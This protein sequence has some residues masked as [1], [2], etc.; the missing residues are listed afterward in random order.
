MSHTTFAAIEILA[1][2]LLTACAPPPPPAASCPAAACS[3][4]GQGADDACPDEGQG[5]D[6]ACPHEGHGTGQG[7]SGEGACPGARRGESRGGRRG[8]APGG[9]L[10]ATRT[11][12]GG[13]ALVDM[14]SGAIVA[15][16]AGGG[17]DGPEADIACDPWMSRVLVF[18]SDPDAEWGEIAGHSIDV[19]PGG[20]GQPPSV[21]LGARE[22]EVWVDGLARVAASPYGALVFEDG[23]AG[24][25]WKLVSEQGP[26]PSAYGPR[27]AS[28]AAGSGPGGLFHAAALTYGPSSDGLDLRFATVEQDG[29]HIDSVEPLGLSPPGDWPSARAA[30]TAAGAHLI[31][32]EQGNVLV[33]LVSGG[34]AA[35]WASVPLAAPIDGFH[36]AAALPGGDVLVGLA[37]GGADVVAVRLGPDGAP[38]CAAALDLPGE[39]Q[40]GLLFFS[41]G[42]TVAGPG[43]VLAATSSG[44]FAVQVTGMCP[45]AVALDPAF[46][47]DALRGPLD[48]C[49]AGH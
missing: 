17:L 38:A 21:A 37:S 35:P 33:S 6:D 9:A 22:H 1:A 15:E 19:G 49:P 14:G 16:A 25:R 28:L 11:A 43:R 45:L 44:V 20:G 48:A 12:T 47:G 7:G 8:A 26:T 4:S 24:P 18:E 23:A 41:R 39:A 42:L 10:V 46:S 36:D 2:A 5:E 31:A 27:P 40:G 34:A 29:I 13:V 3:N 30:W 32:A